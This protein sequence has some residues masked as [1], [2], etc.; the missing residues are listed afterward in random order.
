VTTHEIAERLD[1]QNKNEYKINRH[2]NS[3]YAGDIFLA[4]G[5][6]DI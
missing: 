3:Y 5:A 4:K 2:S 1:T 6:D